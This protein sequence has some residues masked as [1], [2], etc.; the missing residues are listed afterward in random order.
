[1]RSKKTANY[2]ERYR[3]KLNMLGPG[4]I[5]MMIVGVLAAVGVALRLFGLGTPAVIAFSLAGAV[6]AIL[7]LLAAIELHQDRVLNE[8]AARSQY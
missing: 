8:I 6:F 3:H 2:D 1:M 4:Q 5:M 7:L